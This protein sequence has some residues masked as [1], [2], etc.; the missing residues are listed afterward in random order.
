MEQLNTVTQNNA[1][2]SEELSATAEE[3]TAQMQSLADM[4]AFFTI[5]KT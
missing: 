5:H 3:M 1:S 2:L 4:M